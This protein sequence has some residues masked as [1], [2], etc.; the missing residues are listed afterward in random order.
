MIYCPSCGSET[1]IRRTHHTKRIRVCVS[2]SAKIDCVQGEQCECGN[3][4]L[5]GARFGCERC[6]QID[7]DRISGD[8]RRRVLAAVARF[9]WATS[10]DLYLAL[11]V[12]GED[13]PEA[14]KVGSMLRRLA[15]EG[16]VETRG[17]N[18]GME[19]RLAQRGRRVA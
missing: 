10:L 9:D 18:S 14:R 3:P 2:C 17:L 8:T 15:E 1:L 13:G 5:R 12:V 16:L 11:E 19:Y 4:R 6:A 7:Q